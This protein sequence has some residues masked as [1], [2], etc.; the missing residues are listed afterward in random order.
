MA[1]A[2]GVQ[3][4]G[5]LH[6]IR[7]GLLGHLEAGLAKP[8]RDAAENTTRFPLLGRRSLLFADAPR[9]AHLSAIFFSLVETA[10]ANN[11]ASCHHLRLVPNKL[12][13]TKMDE[14][15]HALLPNKF[16]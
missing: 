13:S 8:D 10:K 1:A 6:R 12:T 11:L 14:D 7:A 3:I 2:G 15:A 4:R 9:G 16:E 5:V